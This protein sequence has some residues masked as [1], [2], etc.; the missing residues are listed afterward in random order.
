M[1]GDESISFSNS[2]ET[3]I[4][5]GYNQLSLFLAIKEQQN[6]DRFDSEAIDFQTKQAMVELTRNSCKMKKLSPKREFL[7]RSLTFQASIL[8][9]ET[10]FLFMVRS[11]N[12][13]IPDSRD[14]FSL[15]L[16]QTFL[17]NLHWLSTT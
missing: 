12:E 11:D 15:P 14:E 1:D 5:S 10:T 9:L 4:G 8:Q 6:D 2:A 13:K 3:N 17:T 16:T 7:I